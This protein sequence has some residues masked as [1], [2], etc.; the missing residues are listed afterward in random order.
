MPLYIRLYAPEFELVRIL[1]P[2]EAKRKEGLWR[3]S[4]A[5]SRGPRVSQTQYHVA[6]ALSRGGLTHE[7]EH[8][9]ADGKTLDM[10]QPDSRLAVEFDGPWHFLWDSRGLATDLKGPALFKRRVLRRLGWRC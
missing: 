4:S 3:P 9:A 10:A 6:A 1:A 7:C 8:R 2:I 5:T